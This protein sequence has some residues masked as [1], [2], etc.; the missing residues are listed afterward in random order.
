MTVSEIA[1][2][3]VSLCRQGKNLEA[4][5]KHYSPNVISIEAEG[6]PLEVKGIEAVRGKSQ[7]FQEN[8][9]VHSGEISD[10]MVTGNHFAMTYKIDVTNKQIGQRYTMEEICVYE[11]KEGKIVKEQF[12]YNT[13]Q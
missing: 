8:M 3:L 10:P 12:F 13:G 1:N 4:I 6:E 2:D 7:Y 11:V 5:E 9:E